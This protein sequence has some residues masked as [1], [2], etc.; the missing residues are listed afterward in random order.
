MLSLVFFIKFKRGYVDI[1]KSQYIAGSSVVASFE[2]MTRGTELLN[3]LAVAVF[4]CVPSRMILEAIFFNTINRHYRWLN[5]TNVLDALIVVLNLA[6][7][8]YSFC[9]CDMHPYKNYPNFRK[10]LEDVV[11]IY[12]MLLGFAMLFLWMRV[13]ILLR[14]SYTLGPLLRTIRFMASTIFVFVILYVFF[15]I[16]FSMTANIYPSPTLDDAGVSLRYFFHLF[17]KNLGHSDDSYNS[18]SFQ[19]ASD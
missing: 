5:P 4:I 8:L 7:F 1:I 10:R 18:D 13:I 9:V 16:A 17:S 12:L 3:G 15:L 19:D 2:D 11:G 14:V 6:A